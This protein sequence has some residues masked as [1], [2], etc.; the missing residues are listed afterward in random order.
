MSR[1]MNPS[2]S[3]DTV[4]VSNVLNPSSTL[5]RPTTS[6]SPAPAPMSIRFVLER[7]ILTFSVYSPALT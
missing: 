6:V 3:T 5:R 4:A 2:A 1:I 7:P